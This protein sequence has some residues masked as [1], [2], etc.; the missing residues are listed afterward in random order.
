MPQQSTLFHNV[1]IWLHDDAPAG[2]VQ[3]VAHAALTLLTEIPGVQSLVVAAPA[4]SP[5]PLVDGSYALVLLMEFPD[6]AALDAYDSHP[7][8]VRFVEGYKQWF[9]RL[10][11]YNSSAIL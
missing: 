3:T 2:A 9:S 1:Y 10:E 4:G 8:H 5:H 6:A 7:D 11:V